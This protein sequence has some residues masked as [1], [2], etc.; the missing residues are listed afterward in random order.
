MGKQS[1]LM[2]MG[3]QSVVKQFK[4]VKKKSLGLDEYLI[5]N[6]IIVLHKTGS[7]NVLFGDN[8]VRNPTYHRLYKN[9]I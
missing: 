3:K 6:Y 2:N 7:Q 9:R 5:V 1:V 4:S 8:E